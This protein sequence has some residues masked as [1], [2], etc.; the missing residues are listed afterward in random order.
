[1]LVRQE[2]ALIDAELDR[3]ERLFQPLVA[4]ATSSPP[5]LLPLTP[6]TPSPVAGAL[7]I[8]LPVPPPLPPLPV[9]Q[10]FELKQALS[11]GRHIEREIEAVANSAQN[12]VMQHTVASVSATPSL[13]PLSA[14]A[15]AVSLA[16]PRAAL[17]GGL[18]SAGLELDSARAVAKQCAVNA[19]L[20]ARNEE[21]RAFLMKTYRTGRRC[22][23]LCVVDPTSAARLMFAGCMRAAV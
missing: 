11:T 15:S 21:A 17:P 4:S 20:A 10:L 2:L 16:H 18:P 22:A 13:I 12:A 5:P 6:L 9:T 19:L 1:M 23:M 7:R 14:I 3:S 8:P